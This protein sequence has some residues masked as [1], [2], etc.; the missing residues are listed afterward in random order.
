MNMLLK[1]ITVVLWTIGVG[2]C[3]MLPQAEGLPQLAV[4][5]TGTAIFH[6][7]R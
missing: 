4:L 5:L 2:L 7:C 6:L 1:T 3:L